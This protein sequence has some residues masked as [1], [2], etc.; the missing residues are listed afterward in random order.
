L[1]K[2][3]NLNQKSL[4]AVLNIVQRQISYY[5][6]GDDLP[7]LTKIIAIADYFKVSIDYLV[8]HEIIEK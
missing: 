6:N 1:R 4:G 2:S 8:G 5:E 7:S 3:R